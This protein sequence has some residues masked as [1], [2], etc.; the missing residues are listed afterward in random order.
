MKS[1]ISLIA[2]LIV[3][4][5][6]SIGCKY[7]VVP[8]DL[9]EEK[10][11]SEG[12]GAQVTEVQNAGDGTMKLFITLQNYTG[13]WSFMKAV[14]GKPAVLNN[15]GEKLECD[16]TMV[17]T[18]GYRLAP[19]LQMRGYTVGPK[20]E[21]LTQLIYVQCDA[22]ELDDKATLT[23][24]YEYFNGP[25]DYYHQDAN[26]SAGSLELDLGDIKTDLTYPIM[27]GAE[28][29]TTA[30]DAE[31]TALSGNIIHLAGLERQADRLIFT[32]SNFNPTE[33]AL[34]TH[35]GIPP[36]IGAD[37]IIYGKYEIMDIAS[38]P[39]TASNGSVEWTTEVMLPEEANGLYILFSY[40]ATQARLYENL[41]ID[42]TD[43]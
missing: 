10:V 15:G 23:I 41:L 40:E 1:K 29:V 5:L 28:V 4:M 24:D 9:I 19:G 18:G 26:K 16:A 6:A 8:D 3:V 25:L 43:R 30:S 37:G 33:F 34:R 13:A 21:P 42:I 22:V 32:W 39:I 31:I 35:I 11:A 38:V 2:V 20:K 17:S 36:V 7:I 14:E 12:W 27:E